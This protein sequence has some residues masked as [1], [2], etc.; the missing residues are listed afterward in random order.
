MSN[1][2]DMVISEIT[3]PTQRDKQKKIGPSEIG[4][5]CEICVARALNNDRHSQSFSL[6]PWIGTAV[7]YFMEKKTFDEEMH[8]LRVTVGEIEGYGTIHGTCDMVLTEPDGD[9]IVDWKVVGLKKIKHYKLNGIPEQ[10][11]YQAMLYGLGAKNFGLDINKIAIV[12]IP[13]DSGNVKDIWVHEEQWQPEM[14]EAAL[15]RAK[16]IFDHIKT[17]GYTEL[18]S[19]SECYQCNYTW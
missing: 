18:E 19:D 15:A 4:N 11:R 7:H 14:A 12:F 10:Y 16:A 1:I 6:Y 3:Q 17:K 8:E 9:A 13:R 2:R 5:P